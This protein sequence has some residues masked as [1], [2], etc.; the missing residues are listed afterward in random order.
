ML[1]KE[2][3]ASLQGFSPDKPVIT[4][5]AHLDPFYYDSSD[6]TANSVILVIFDMEDIWEIIETDTDNEIIN[7]QVIVG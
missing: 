2:L 6:T 7:K 5:Q 3:A 4:M 1:T